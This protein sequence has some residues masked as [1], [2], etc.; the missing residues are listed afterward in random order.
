MRAMEPRDVESMLAIQ[1]AS[2]QISQWNASDYD[3]ASH[4][5]TFGWVA[6]E[7]DRIIGFLVAR[8]VLDECEILNLAVDPDFRRRGV[9]TSLLRALV[10]FAAQRASATIYLEVRESNAPARALYGRNGFREV[11]RRTNYYKFPIE[12]ALVLQLG[13][14]Q[15]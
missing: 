13:L 15:R 9:A 5:G 12:G 8:R 6:A 3:L 7:K 10:E 14:R 11:G 4:P 1:S 2:P